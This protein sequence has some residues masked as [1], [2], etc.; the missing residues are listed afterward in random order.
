MSLR[1]GAYSQRVMAPLTRERL[2][3]LLEAHATCRDF[4]AAAASLARAEV[5]AAL[6]DARLDALAVDDA[7][8]GWVLREW[9]STERL[10]VT[11]RRELGLTSLAE[12]QL[13]REEAVADASRVVS[14]DVIRA[15]GVD[16]ARDYLASVGLA[17]A[18]E[19]GETA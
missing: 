12:A 15:A 11:L 1:H 6:L 10:A 2:G 16:R 14:L 4:P 8:W 17:R 13:H 19:P 3:E 7:S 18:I 9:R 5:R